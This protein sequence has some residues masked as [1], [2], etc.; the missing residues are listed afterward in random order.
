MNLSCQRKISVCL[1]FVE[2]DI[3]NTKIEESLNKLIV[4]IKNGYQGYDF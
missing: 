2:G 3:E 4:N 1:L